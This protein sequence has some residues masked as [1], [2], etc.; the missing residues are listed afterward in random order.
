MLSSQEI[1]FLLRPN[2]MTVSR[3]SWEPNDPR[4]TGQ[5]SLSFSLFLFFSL[6]LF[7]LSLSFSLLEIKHLGFGKRAML[8][9]IVQFGRPLDDWSRNSGSNPD[10]RQFSFPFFFLFYFLFLDH[11]GF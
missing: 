8:A 11:N 7:F 2:S 6:S 1:E 3:P 10:Q 9:L 5:V 4:W